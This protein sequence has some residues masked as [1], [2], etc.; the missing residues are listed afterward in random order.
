M[1][2]G[3]MASA[4]SARIAEAHVVA[5]EP[6]HDDVEQDEVEGI[7][8]D[9]RKRLLPAFGDFHVV[10]MESE[11]VLEELQVGAGVSRTMSTRPGRLP[12]ASV[13]TRNRP[14]GSCGLEE[15][16]ERLQELADVDGLGA[17]TASNP[18][19]RMRLR[20]WSMHRGRDRHHRHALRSVQERNSA[21]TSKPLMPGSWMSSSAASG[22]AARARSRPLLAA[23][24][25][26]H[27]VA[28]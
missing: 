17:R 24:D 5:A 18:A 20:S 27:L 9:R 25:G 3:S 14:G 28:V 11:E 26:R 2:T 22:R 6:G 8:L 7:A 21:S 1:T 4:G 16:F 12:R 15:R 10:A 19:A 23:L 13:A